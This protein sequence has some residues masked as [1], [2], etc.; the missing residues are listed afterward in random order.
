MIHWMVI[1]FFLPYGLCFRGLK[2][3]CREGRYCSVT[4]IFVLVLGDRIGI[5][6]YHEFGAKER[7]DLLHTHGVLT[8]T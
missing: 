1:L 4:L 2:I 6:G 8:N 5:F 7:V 3:V